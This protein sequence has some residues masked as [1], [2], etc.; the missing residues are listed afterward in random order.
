MVEAGAA[1][2][3]EGFIL[4][5]SPITQHPLPEESEWSESEAKACSIRQSWKTRRLDP[6]Q[7]CVGQHS[8]PTEFRR[9]TTINL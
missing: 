3:A 9:D 8:T 5:P 1:A 7:W 6:T 2:E 4:S